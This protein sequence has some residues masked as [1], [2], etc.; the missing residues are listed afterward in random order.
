[1]GIR[2]N[3]LEWRVSSELIPYNKAVAVME[4]RA[5]D[6][7]EGSRPEMIWLLEHPSLYT[8]GT[9]AK[10]P[11][12]LDTKSLPVY[13]SNRGG[14]YTYHGPGQRIAYVMI[15]LTK[16]GCDVRAFV[17]TLEQW[18]IDTLAVFGIK[19]ERRPGRVGIWV[20]NK[21]VDQKIAALGIRLRR[22]VSFHGIALNISPD[23]SY[24]QGIV[25]CGL[26]QYGV[27][28]CQ[29]LGVPIS[30]AEVDK[31]LQEQWKKNK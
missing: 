20:N 18:I 19:G 24:F 22:W 14:Q 2:E 5:T 8:A 7:R 16:R 23:L 30:V 9:S 3:M 12:L 28:S 29:D 31:V 27:T 6:I 11:D 26:P 15:D 10:R 17:T 13:E 4:Q 21:G 1:M 25:P